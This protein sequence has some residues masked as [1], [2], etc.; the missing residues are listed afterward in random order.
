MDIK[1]AENLFIEWISSNPINKTAIKVDKI[2][3]QYDLFG[4]QSNSS[5]S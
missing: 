2:I 5:K 3:K 4:N 1:T